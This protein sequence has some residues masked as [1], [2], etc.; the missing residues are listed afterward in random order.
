MKI[1]AET[2]VLSLIRILWK[3]VILPY[4][5]IYCL[6]IEFMS[7]FPLNIFVLLLYYFEI[8]EITET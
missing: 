8:L 3:K 6:P 4:N 7:G 5:I 2:N 1:K